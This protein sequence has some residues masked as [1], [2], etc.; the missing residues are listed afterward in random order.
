MKTKEEIAKIICDPEVKKID[1]EMEPLRDRKIEVGSIL[2]RMQRQISQI[3]LEKEILNQ[4][5]K[6]EI[7]PVEAHIE[8]QKKWTHLRVWLRKIHYN[9]ELYFKESKNLKLKLL[10]LNKAHEQ[11]VAEM[12]NES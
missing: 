6:G 7:L 12:F 10:Q 3:K 8:K 1:A 5:T 2:Q 4:S 9:Q 11:R